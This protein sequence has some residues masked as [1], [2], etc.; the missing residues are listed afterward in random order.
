VE[1]VVHTH[2]CQKD[3]EVVATVAVGEGKWQTTGMLGKEPVHI[4]VV[5]HPHPI[6]KNPAA[7]QSWFI[8]KW[9]QNPKD[10]SE[11]GYVWSDLDGGGDHD[12]DDHGGGDR[13][14][15]PPILVPVVTQKETVVQVRHSR[16]QSTW[17][18]V[19]VRSVD[20]GRVLCACVSRNDIK[21]FWGYW[22]IWLCCN[23][24]SWAWLSNHLIIRQR[25]G[26]DYQA[27]W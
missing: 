24:G 9:G 14:T 5:S 26:L 20:V 27:L 17:V 16:N 2:P 1:I 11:K 7:M 10:Q 15:H 3:W 23:I 25:S 13:G 18:H 8:L 22:L 6:H 12:G 21:L 4:S 19:I